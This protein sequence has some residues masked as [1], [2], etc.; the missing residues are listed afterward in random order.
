MRIW[1]WILT[2]LGP[3]SFIGA[4][5]MGHNIMEPSFWLALGLYLI[6]AAKQKGKEKDD[7]EKWRN[8]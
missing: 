6:Y 4:L 2:V 5:S 7:I 1:G 8:K 3:F